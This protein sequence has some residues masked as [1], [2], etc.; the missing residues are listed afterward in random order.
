MNYLPLLSVVALLGCAAQP[1]TPPEPP[2]DPCVEAFAAVA[3]AAKV[4]TPLVEEC[5][6]GIL[7]SCAALGALLDH[8]QMSSRLPQTYACLEEGRISADH[9]IV[10]LTMVYLP[11]FN[12]KLVKLNKKLG[13]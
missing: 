5:Q 1:I 4:G 8:A 7:L 11:D 12:R 3:A 9:P 6:S 10:T 2:P 13:L